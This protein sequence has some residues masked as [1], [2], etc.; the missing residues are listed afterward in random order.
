M[1]EHNYLYKNSKTLKNKYGIKDPQRLYERYAH[2]T[3]REAMN[4]R[5]DPP[6]Q[7]FGLA[8]LKLIHW[9]LFHRS[10][11]WA[12]HTRDELFTFEDGSSAHMPAMRPKGHKIPFAVGPQIQKE[13][14]QLERKLTARNNLQGLSRREFA[15]NAAEVFMTLD[16]AHPFRKGNG[17]AQ[18]LFMEKL[19]QAAGYKIDFSFIT[20]ERL[21]QASIAAMQ[22]G[23]TQPMKDLFEDITHPQKFLLL[24]EFISQMRNSGLEEINEHIVVVA[25]E[26]VKYD[27]I[28]KGCAAEGFV[29]ELEDGFVVGHKDDLTPEQVK[30]LQNGDR[31]VFEKS[32]VLDLKEILIPKETLPP[33]TNEE[34]AKRFTDNCGVESYRQEVEHLSKRVYGKSQALN[35]MIESINID[36]SLGAEF[37]D[38]IAQNPKSFCKLAGRKI[39][40]IRSPS[41]RRAEEAVPQLCE[42]LKSYADMAQHTMENLIEQHQREQ[43]RIAHSVE[44]PGRDLQQLFTLSPEQQREVLSHSPTLQKQLHTFARQLQ[45]RLSS[46][47]HRAIQENNPL[48]LS[49]MLGVSESKAKEITKAVKQTKE[50]HCQLRTLKISRS[51]ARALTN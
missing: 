27:G 51:S 10:F 48:K 26:G 11:E 38:Q 8:Y 29:I 40:G 44:K 4:L 13:L 39:L 1:L 35:E 23:N 16:H 28:Y 19:G 32:N 41:R 21:T 6:P 7:R 31:I 24:K 17:R 30:T 46:E 2:D 49:C 45:N 37:A 25:K 9:N 3:A 36:P 20:K 34:L 14:K 18:R 50:A 5:F 33:L 42:A 47:E 12:G 15:E 22:H 43:R